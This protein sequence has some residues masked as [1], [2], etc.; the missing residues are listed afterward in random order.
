MSIDVASRKTKLMVKSVAWYTISNVLLRSVSL[1]TSPIFTR[2]LSTSDYGVVSNFQTWTQLISCITGLG[3]GTAIIRGK[4]EFGEDFK[5]FLSSVQALGFI[6]AISTLIICLPFLG[7]LSQFMVLDRFCIIFMLIYLVF[8]P[9]VTFMQIN[10]RFEYKYKKNILIAV[11]N[12]LGNVVCSITLILMWTDKRYIGRIIGTSIP[13]L[14][15]GIVFFVKIFHD[16]KIFYNKGYWKYAL[17]LG[18]LIIPHSLAM[19]A[20]GQIDRIMI[21]RMCGESEAGIYSFGY[22][23]AIV[24]GML[25]NAINEGIQ[26]E[27]YDLIQ[28]KAYKNLNIM[29]RNICLIVSAIGFAMILFGPEALKILGT[30]SYYEAR[31]VIFPIVIGSIFQLMYQN[32]A[33]VEIYAKD[34]KIIAVGSILAALINIVLNYIFIPIYGYFIAGYT[35]LAGYFF[36]MVFH[37]WGARKVMKGEKIFIGRDIVLLSV[38]LIVGGMFCNLCYFLEDYVRYLVLVL[39]IFMTIWKERTFISKY[40]GKTKNYK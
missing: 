36:L 23:Y 20:L 19:I 35:T 18:L 8:S 31:W 10:Y 4:V 21:I 15:L 12:T 39:L 29:T 11:F 16:G 25:T 3:L 32:Y 2:L 14:L 40:F 38:T 22:A 28:K 33:C 13:M 6:S 27:I 7:E 5:K 24:I 9:S 37:F 17:R 26:P 1:I 34:T 30:A